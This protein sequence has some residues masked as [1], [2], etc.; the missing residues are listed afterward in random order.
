MLELQAGREAAFEEL[1]KILHHRVFH[2]VRRL[3]RDEGRAEDLTQEVFVRVYRARTD[4]RPMG[5]FQSWIF[6]IAH[7]LALNELRALRRRRRVISERAAFQVEEDPVAEAEDQR[8]DGPE[9][10]AAAGELASRLDRLICALPENQRAALE[11]HRTAELSYQE[12]ARLLCVTPL[13]V[14]SLLVRARETLRQALDA[15]E[16]KERAPREVE[17]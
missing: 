4:Y 17:S 13:A 9:E 8:G 12:I 1:V 6:T 15:G 3:V 14:K 10:R 16:P 7:R 11:L 2:F 5:T